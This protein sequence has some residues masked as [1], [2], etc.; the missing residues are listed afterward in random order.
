MTDNR[1]TKDYEF[2]WIVLIICLTILI[3]AGIS[4]YSDY[5]KAKMELAQ[6]KYIIEF[7]QEAYELR[8]LD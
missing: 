1:A 3:K 2:M 4:S 7:N 5:K 8:K 6:P